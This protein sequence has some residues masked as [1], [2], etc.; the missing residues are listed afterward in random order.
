MQLRHFVRENIPN[1]E[2]TC[3]SHTFLE[4][5]SLSPESKKLIT[6]FVKF[7][8]NDS[9]SANCMTSAWEK[10]IKASL[11]DNIWRTA[12]SRIHSCSI[13]C[14]HRLIQF[15]V[16][17]RFHFSKVMLHKFYSS[18]SPLSDKCKLTDG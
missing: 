18:V 14:R 13:S 5:L 16:I 17:H 2:T 6:K 4:L 3:E 10:E 15:K 7:F 11:P 12:L 9:T 8:S 1:F